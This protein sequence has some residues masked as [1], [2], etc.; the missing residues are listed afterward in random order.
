MA[1][2]KIKLNGKIIKIG[3]SD[4]KI[5]LITR[6]K[7]DEE[8]YY[9]QYIPKENR[10]EINSK[11]NNLDEVNTLLHE[12]LHAVINILGNSPAEGTLDE[13]R[14]ESL[15]NNLANYLTQIL[16]DN[17]WLIEYLSEKMEK[18]KNATG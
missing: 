5:K 14:E 16:R 2:K 8:G 7:E 13:N 11:L 18:Y 3:Y 1:T 15:T 10:I 17:N 9:G 12:I 4:I 6:S